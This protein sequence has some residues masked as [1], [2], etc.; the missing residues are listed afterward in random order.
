MSTPPSISLNDPGRIESRQF[1]V[2]ASEKHGIGLTVKYSWLTCLVLLVPEV[3]NEAGR[4]TRELCSI[5][6]YDEALGWWCSLCWGRSALG[7]DGVS[8]MPGLRG[9][10]YLDGETL[11]TYPRD[12]AN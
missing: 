10:T 7:G 3:P 8:A 5:N 1:S 12:E 4:L 9:M 2:R 6:G 11:V